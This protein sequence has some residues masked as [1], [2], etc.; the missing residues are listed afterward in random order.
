M[1][2]MLRLVAFTFLFSL[3][4]MHMNAQ[5]TSGTITGRVTD[6]GG[7]IVPTA[8]VQLTNQDT[9]V[10]V[11]T[12]VLS[13]GDFTFADVPPGTYLVTVEAKGFK[14]FVKRDLVLTASE[15]LS[16]GTLV[17]QVGAVEQ[18][19]TVTA[20]VTPIQTASAEVSGDIDVHQID[21]ELAPGRD[22][23]ALTRTIPGVANVGEGA[24][25]AGSSTTP[26]VNGIRNIYNSTDI[27]GMSG[28]P[29]PGQGV[30]T[31]PNMDAVA[32]VKVETSGY[33]AQYG[34]D[35][36]GVQIQVVT[37]NGTNQ[38]HGTAYYYNRNEDYNANSWGN[39][40]AGTARGRY[41]YNTVGGNLG[42]PIFWPGHFNTNKNK[43]FF[44]YSQEYWPIQS[45][46]V[47]NYQIP[48]LAQTQGNFGNTPLQGSNPTTYINIRMPGNAA[49][50]CAAPGAK[51]TASS[52]AGCWNYGGAANTT[53]PNDVINPAWMDKQ[54][55]YFLQLLYNTATTAPG[56][57]S[58]ANAPISVTK[59]N[60]NYIFNSTANSPIGQQIARVDFAPTD[61]LRM[62][63]RAL[64][65]QNDNTSFTSAANNLKWLMPVDYQT[66]RYNYAYDVTYAFSPTLMNEFVGGWSEFAENQIYSAAALAPALKSSSGYNLPQLD[67]ANVYNGLQLLP[68]VSFGGTNLGSNSPSYGWDS[69]FPMYD[70]ASVW[71]A[72]DNVTKIW[73][74]HNLMFGFQYLTGH[75]LQ[76]HGS[77]GTPE[78]TFSF[79][80]DANNPNDSTYAFANAY[81]GNFDNYAEPVG[82][83]NSSGQLTAGRHDYNPRFYDPEWFVQDQWRVN[84]HLTLDYG[85][86]FAWAVPNSLEVGGN[87]VP[88]LYAS[89]IATMAPPKLYQYG[90]SGGNVVTIDPTNPTGPTYPASYAGL[91]VPSTYTGALGTGNTAIGLISTS[92]HAGYPAGLVSG[93]GFQ[94]VPRLG[95][96]YDPQG[97]GKTA[98]RGHFAA[99]MYPPTVGGQSGDM[100]HNAPE[101]YNPKQY[102]G[103]VTGNTN[104][105]TTNTNCT[106]GFESAGS[107]VGPTSIGNGFEQH[108]QMVKIYDAGLQMQQAIGF[109]TVVTLGYAGNVMRHGTG[110]TNLNEVP[111]GAEFLPQNQ[112]CTKMT[113]T[114]CTAFSPEPDPYFVPYPGFTNTITYRTT[115]YDSNYNAMQLSVAHRYSKGLEFDL[116]YTWSKSMDFA[117]E[118]DSSVATYQNTRFWNYGPTTETPQQYLAVN[119]VW[120][121]PEIPHSWSNLV[122]RPV[123]NGWQIS[124]IA[125]Y[126]AH[127]P[128]TLSYTTADTVN[129]TGG[130][131]GARI[132]VTGNPN[133]GGPHH[134]PNAA[135]PYYFN[136]NTVARPSTGGYNTTTG[137]VVP[138]NG[139]TWNEATIVMLPPVLNFDT[140]LFKNIPIHERLTFQLRFESYNTLN[141][142][143]L[144]GL[145]TAA[146]FS[147]FAGGTTIP[148]QNG[149]LMIN[150]TSTQT[151]AAF[152]EIDP[153]KNANVNS[154]FG[155]VLQLAGRISF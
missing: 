45:P 81:L 15:R 35:S 75:Y 34:Q 119:Y 79:S 131:D 139:Y 104:G 137:Q 53:T 54:S 63:G 127:L 58:Q 50:T 96:A 39:N 82:P 117:D 78:G 95:F 135:T 102:Y 11:T 88:A 100:T 64:L 85:V 86:R 76:A 8:S 59:N 33:Q 136:P 107:L 67:P 21:N 10:S 146:K 109:G 57:V 31:S 66:P 77:T 134:K 40:Y 7:A 114:T 13:G 44:F 120:A 113:G 14:K 103:C 71:E 72:N 128:T 153:T 22:W 56:W 26:Y 19:I 18:S 116:A 65:T 101:E 84:S 115:G 32:E 123:M 62:Y 68:G 3:C 60:Y 23:M 25:T 73:R 129:T 149:N 4:V 36:A 118:Y 12:K 46:V 37:K 98:I 138:S 125:T 144:N 142:P 141:S 91:W 27:D 9:N 133:V 99:F 6:S 154:S 93:D 97:N 61:K 30:D 2:L 151:N 126:Q 110:Q 70:R 52:Y 42:G 155:R 48:T 143:E 51:T 140:A 24:A 83:P 112:Y 121:V 1:K 147:A 80:S 74:S 16:A 111:Y 17:L 43:L 69:R 94:W 106:G 145:I 49:A 124:G 38:F 41:R 152:G 150:G 28:S 122:T 130:G 132:L 55:Q 108:G 29:R 90:L 105:G 148:T 5:T 87:F 92:N 20:E 47:Q 89:Q